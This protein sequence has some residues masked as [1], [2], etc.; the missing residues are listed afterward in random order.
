MGMIVHRKNAHSLHQ[1]KYVIKELLMDPIMITHS[2]AI[3]KI[4]SLLFSIP[5][6]YIQPVSNV[7]YILVHVPLPLDL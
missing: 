3:V 4:N 6:V 2:I 7:H 1:N 5:Y